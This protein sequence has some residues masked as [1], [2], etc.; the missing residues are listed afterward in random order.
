L[1]LASL[2]YAI[3]GPVLTL[4][5]IRRRRLERRAAVSSLTEDAHNSK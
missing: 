5:H 1:F 2:G 4:I 3:S